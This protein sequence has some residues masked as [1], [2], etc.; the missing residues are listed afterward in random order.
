MNE[1]R[2]LTCLQA[3]IFFVTFVYQPELHE[4]YYT[5]ILPTLHIQTKNSQIDDTK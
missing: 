3:I 4:F 2:M 1:Y 5:F